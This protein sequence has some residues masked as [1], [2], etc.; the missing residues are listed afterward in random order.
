MDEPLATIE[1]GNSRAEIY[2][3]NLPGQFTI[4]YRSQDGSLLAE[5][6]L[7]GVSSYH[8]R[9]QEIRSRL[10]ELAKGHDPSGSPLSDSG[11]Y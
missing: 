1:E 10:H 4:R 5:E 2:E 11:E 3:C 6:P 8:Q 9:E 7:S